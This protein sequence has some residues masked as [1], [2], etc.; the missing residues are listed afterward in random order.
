MAFSFIL[1]LAF[2]FFVRVKVLGTFAAP[3]AFEDTG[4]FL[5]RL[6]VEEISDSFPGADIYIFYLYNTGSQILSLFTR[7]VKHGQL[8]LTPLAL[9]FLLM[10]VIMVPA[11]LQELRERKQNRLLVLILFLAI[12][13]SAMIGH[14]YARDRIMAVASVCYAVLLMVSFARLHL[15]GA[16]RA[17]TTKALLSATYLGWAAL[18]LVNVGKIHD[19]GRTYR[20]FYARH[21][22]FPDERVSAE[23][24]DAARPRYDFFPVSGAA[25]E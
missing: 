19:E 8:R 23:I 5:R 1:A 4:F 11:L 16:A 21:A 25:G 13:G 17:R 18:V 15:T 9:P 14:K 24:Y 6:S 2:Y 10:L 7:L 20:K 12:L 22:D 3:T